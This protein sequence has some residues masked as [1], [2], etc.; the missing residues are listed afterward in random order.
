MS[1]TDY[2]LI[3]HPLGHS[4]SPFIH[5]S[6]LAAAR[7]N[8]TYRLFDL[9]PAELPSAVPRLLRELSGFNCTIPHKEKIIPFLQGLDP[10]AARC[11]AVNTVSRGIGYNTDYAGFLQD[12]P[13]MAGHNILILGAG[14]VSRTMA[15]AA[16]ASGADI[17]LLARRSEQS[18]AL[19]QAVRNRH[20]CR[21]RCPANLAE[22]L[23]E[24]PFNQ[25]EPRPWALLNGTPLGLWPRTD[26]LPFP[27]ELLTHFNW[28]YDTIYNP[29]ATRLI[30]AARSRGIPARS[31]LGMLFAQALLAEKI[32][33]PNAIFPEA[34]LAAIKKHLTRKVLEQFPLTLV[35]TGFMG[36]GKSTVGS[37]LAEILDLPLTDLDHEI[38]AA[39]G[40]TVAEIFAAAGEPVFR[41]ME[42]QQLSRLLRT[43]RSQILAAGGGALLDPAAEA[44]VRQN[45]AL[46]IYLDT[47][48]PL[49]RQRLG[50]GEGRPLLAGQGDDRLESLFWQREPR[51][52]ALADLRI[53]GSGSPREIAAALAAGLGFEGETA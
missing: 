33:H 20:E 23:S 45:P 1:A 19:A 28:V 18:E 16:A 42:Q 37:C 47:P 38:E 43:G 9:E 21:I 29:V 50:G 40:R 53:D 39:S 7:L 14:G 49:I 51:Y 52:R 36:S 15:F 44:L 6:L 4:L 12:C 5:E 8:G 31:G 35:L 25:P 46:V 48:L 22:W 27:P 34:A 24:E 17:W 10:A 32:W 30:L 26:G 13:S 3:G 11:G 41:A 2:G